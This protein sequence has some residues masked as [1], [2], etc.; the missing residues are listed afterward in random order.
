MAQKNDV[1]QLKEAVQN[2]PQD[3]EAWKALATVLA[4]QGQRQQALQAYRHSLTLAGT[5]GQVLSIMD[6]LGDVSVAQE[7]R[8]RTGTPFHS[9]GL[10]SGVSLPLW[11][12]VFLGL[13]SFLMML[14]LAVAQQWAPV[15]LVWS[16]WISSLVLGYS[17]ILTS[18][19]AMFLGGQEQSLLTSALSKLGEHYPKAAWLLGIPGAL[20]MLVFF[21]FHFLFF[22][23]IHSVFLNMFFPLLRPEALDTI[24]LQYF[25]GLIATCIRR[26][27]P[28]I[29]MSAIA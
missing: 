8:E 10:L 6:F 17:F 25:V 9:V 11:F 1:E 2:D 5:P 15:D 19:L 4:E 22:H 28:F 23:F 29:F 3:A 13:F 27:W 12:Q 14:L 20:F 21:S 24:G 16:L 26:Y 18:I 7:E